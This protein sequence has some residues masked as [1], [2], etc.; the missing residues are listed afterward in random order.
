M[1]GGGGGGGLLSAITGG[2]GAQQYDTKA[3]SRFEFGASVSSPILKPNDSNT[4][5]KPD[6][7][8]YTHYCSISETILETLQDLEYMQSIF[9]A[10]IIFLSKDYS[11]P[12]QLTLWAPFLETYGPVE[13]V[14]DTAY[15]YCI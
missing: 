1:P 5:A 4:T 12:F 14:L 15:R 7:A 3:Q 11:C 10:K 8:Q 9:N 2:D 13:S 6:R